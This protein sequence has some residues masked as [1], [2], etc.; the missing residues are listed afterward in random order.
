[1]ATDHLALQVSPNEETKSA[2][3]S[4]TGVCKGTQEV[5]RYLSNPLLD[6]GRLALKRNWD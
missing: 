4:D 2:E 6:Y 3:E 5:D 1:M